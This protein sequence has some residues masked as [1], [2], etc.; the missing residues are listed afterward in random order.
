MPLPS[1]IQLAN[2]FGQWVGVSPASTYGGGG[3]VDRPAQ[4]GVLTFAYPIK[5]PYG[6]TTGSPSVTTN[7]THKIYTF[8]ANG[9][10]RF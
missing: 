5:F 4:N 1:F 6:K 8:T 2:T 3:G 9:T 7:A 10:F